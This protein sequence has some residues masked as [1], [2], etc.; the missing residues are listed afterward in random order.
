MIIE[1]TINFLKKTPPFQFLEESLLRVIAGSLSLQFY[2]KD[3]VI[4]RQGDSVSDSVFIIKKGGVRISMTLDDEDVIVDYR[5]EGD[6]F[7]FLSLIGNERQK[8]TVVAID[9][10]ICYLLGRE[11]MKEL[12]DR[13]PGIAEFFMSYLSRFVDK[14]FREMHRKSLLYGGADRLLFTTKVGDV[15]R[16]AIT[17]SEDT[18]I[19]DAARKMV[20]EKVSSLIVTNGETGLPSGII[21][22]RDLREKVVAMGRDISEPVKN[23]MT[24]SLIRADANESCFSAIT[25]MIKY[26]IHHILVIKDGLLHGIMTNHDVMLLQGTSPLSLSHSI[27]NQ[28]SIEGLVS[29]SKRMNGLVGLLLKEGARSSS[30]LSIVTEINDRLVRKVISLAEKRVG[31]PPVPYCWVV[32]GSEGRKEQLFKTDQDNAIIYADS[33][34]TEAKEYFSALAKIIHD[35][36]IEIGYPE[37]SS[38]FMAINPRWCQP[39]SVW[40]E[41]FKNW[42]ERPSH[43][44]IS[45]HITFFDMRPIYGKHA[46]AEELRD[47]FISYIRES[48]FLKVMAQIITRNTPPVGFIKAYSIERNGKRSD[49]LDLKQRGTIPLVDIIRFFSMEMGVRETSTIGRINILR[50]RHPILREFA[51]E[52]EHVYEFMMLLRIHHQFEQILSG[53]NPDNIIVPSKLSTLEKKTIKEAFHLISRLQ[54]I[55]AEGYVARAPSSGINN[56]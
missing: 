33:S 29:I 25:K 24:I 7:G 9:D 6:N 35:G 30:I 28:H 31:F 17:V 22:D 5:G 37:C 39:L 14:T 13:S 3:T 47:S 36:L 56:P 20:Q 15:A 55:V 16:E 21:T 8:T 27:D 26:N 42:V 12:L 32:F 11:K 34:A 45:K 10:T 44:V 54:E 41:Y 18:T 48:E 19:R 52:I 4:L 43:E 51:D 46:L 49:V 53:E 2:P 40:K 23:I 1:D 38:N 50:A